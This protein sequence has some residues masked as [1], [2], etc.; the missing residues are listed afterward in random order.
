MVGALSRDTERGQRDSPPR[1][2]A[3]G[4]MHSV[5][6]E[7]GTSP[8]AQP[9]RVGGW[10]RAGAVDGIWAGGGRGAAAQG[11]PG[12]RHP[13]WR[14]KIASGGPWAGEGCCGQM[15]N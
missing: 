5:I 7:C 11:V 13:R 9:V 10:E 14:L 8:A 1:A 12:A 4:E 2:D 3:V 6:P 15:T